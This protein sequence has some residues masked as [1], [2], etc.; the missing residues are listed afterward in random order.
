MYKVTQYLICD[1]TCPEKDFV[2][3]PSI[4]F[5]TDVS[6]QVRQGLNNTR[7]YSKNTLKKWG[8]DITPKVEHQILHIPQI[9]VHT[10]LE[11]WQIIPFWKTI[12]WKTVPLICR[13]NKEP[14]WPRNSPALKNWDTEREQRIDTASGVRSNK[15]WKHRCTGICMYVMYT[16][17]YEM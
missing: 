6:P 11:S 13:A 15:C 8:W 14:R 9:G 3:T 12:D 4:F 10:A 16:H 17:V 1:F 7:G 2:D 5:F